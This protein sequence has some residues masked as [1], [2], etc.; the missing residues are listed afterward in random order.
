VADRYA[1]VDRYAAVANRYAVRD[2][3]VAAADRCAAVDRCVPA[4]H[5]GGAVDHYVVAADRYAVVDHYASVVHTEALDRYVAAVHSEAD[6]FFVP[7]AVFA[8]QS[9]PF[10]DVGCAR[11]RPQAPFQIAVQALHLEP[12]CHSSPDDPLHRYL[13]AHCGQHHPADRYREAG[14]SVLHFAEQNCH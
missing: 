4:D 13:S 12:N 1:L 3:Y 9:F 5:Y 2:R 14:A 10:G 6:R 7:Q 11:Y 8:A